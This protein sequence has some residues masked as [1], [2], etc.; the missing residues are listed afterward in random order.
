MVND[1][2][3][4]DYYDGEPLITRMEQ[5]KNYLDNKFSHVHA[6][7]DLTEINQKIT[8]STEEI[9][10]K[11]T[12]ST[13]ELSQQITNSTAELSEKIEDSKPY[14]CN[15]ATKEDVCKAKCA[16]INKIE[17]SKEEIIKDIDEKFVDLNE[18]VK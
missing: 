16:V 6:D 18:L 2:R 1:I 17:S 14:L 8:E 7:V 10:G 15:L 11:I 12:V 3:V 5:V 9:N 4:Y 13:K